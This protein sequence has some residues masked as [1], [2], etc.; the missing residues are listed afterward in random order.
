MRS[1][2]NALL[3]YPQLSTSVRSAAVFP[4]LHNK[5]LVSV[6]QFCDDGFKVIFT[7]EQV[8]LTKDDLTIIGSRNKSDGLYYIKLTP[9][10]VTNPVR[11][12]SPNS[13]AFNVYTMQT[14]RDLVQYLHRAAFSPVISTWTAAIDAGHFSTWPGLTSQLV[15]KHLPASIATAKGHR[16]QDRQNVRS[17]KP[18][19]SPPLSDPQ[20]VMTKPIFPSREPGIR[21]NLVYCEALEL[22]GKIST[23]QTGRFPTTSNRGNKYLMVLYDHDSNAILAEPLKSRSASE[24]VRAT[25]SLHRYLSERGLKPTFQVLDNECPDSLKQFFRTH[26]VSFQLVPPYIHRTNAAEKAI[27]CFKDHFIAGLCSL[28]P[29]FPLHLWDRLIPQATLTLNL[30]RTS[31]IN[32]RLSSEAQLNG[33]FDFN[34]TPLAPPGTKVL[35]YDTPDHRRTWAAHGIDGWYIGRAPEHYRCYRVYIPKTRAERTAKTVDFFPHDCPIPHTSSAD[36]ATAAACAL[37]DALTHP[38]PPPPLPPSAMSKC[39][40]SRN[41]PKSSTTP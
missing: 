35:V 1:T 5:A 23:D 31:N 8:R 4:T 28:D 33:S 32:P 11:S 20:H 17:T 14:K 24:L 6:G 29:S 26:D 16:R 38:T 2:H 13:A 3:P 19:P 37:A 41:Y 22:T 21:A 25:T 39:E 34:R 30:L 7:A 10:A 15:R 36:A 40:Q 27:G 9:D 12:P 18:K